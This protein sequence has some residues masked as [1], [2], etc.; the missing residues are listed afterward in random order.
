MDRLLIVPAAGLGTR[1]GGSTPKLLVEV[2]GRPMID[3]LWALYAG[4]AERLAV[5]VHP[6]AQELVRR[7]LASVADVFVQ[8]RPVGMLDAVMQARPAVET[9]RPRRVTIT[10]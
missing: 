8:G 9:H 2:N 3:H 5:V 4:I 6:T 1:L 10:W 7:R